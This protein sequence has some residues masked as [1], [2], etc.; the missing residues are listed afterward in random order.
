MVPVL[1]QLHQRYGENVSF[2]SVAGPWNGATQNDLA[3]FL[4]NYGSNWTYTYDSSGSIMSLYG[5]NSTPTFFIIG[6]DGTIITSL[7]GDQT[8]ASLENLIVQ[9]MRS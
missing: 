4:R 6:K 7:Q 8:Y 5:V 3:A 1:E 9:S 2:I